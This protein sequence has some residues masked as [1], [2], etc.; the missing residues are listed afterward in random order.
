MGRGI[1]FLFL[2]HQRWVEN[3]DFSLGSSLQIR[4][5]TEPPSREENQRQTEKNKP[6]KPQRAGEGR[7]KYRG[8]E[9]T[10]YVFIRLFDETRARGKATHVLKPRLPP[11]PYPLTQKKK[12][13]VAPSFPGVPAAWVEQAYP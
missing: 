11:C 12:S 6:L 8:E 13:N 4:A 2:P 1:F 3:L 7:R 10:L 9:H 5:N